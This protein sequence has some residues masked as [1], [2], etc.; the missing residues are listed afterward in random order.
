MKLTTIAIFL[1]ATL[2]T[3]PLTAADRSAAPADAEVY[4]ISPLAGA[5]VTGAVT[6]RFGL[7]G[8]GVAPAGVN[9]ANTGHHHLL[10]NT[11]L[12]AD[13]HQP[14]ASSEQI[15]HFGKGQTETTLELAPG[16][17]QLQLVLGNHGHVP[18]QP[19]VISGTIKITVEAPKS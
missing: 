13:L 15:R 16:T 17:Y 12:P 2:T 3:L 19:P 1:A 5:R 8:M 7:K 18:H 9:L 14:L 11:Q 4:F 10:I 6:V